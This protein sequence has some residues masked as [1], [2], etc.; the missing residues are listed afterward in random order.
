MIPSGQFT[1]YKELARALKS[2]PRAVGQALRRNPTPI[3]V[4]CHRVVAADYSL[5]GYCGKMNSTDKVCLLEKE[6]LCIENY[7]IKD[8]DKMFIFPVG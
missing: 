1:T 8:T 4:P 5:G 3:V 6:G 7:R 2:S